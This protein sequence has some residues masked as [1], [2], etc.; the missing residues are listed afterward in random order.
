MEYRCHYMSEA[1]SGI[2]LRILTLITLI[3]DPTYGTSGKYNFWG[4]DI[5]TVSDSYIAMTSSVAIPPGAI[6]HFNHA[7]SFEPPTTMAG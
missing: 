7:Y 2:I 5:C 4:Y 3:G 1:I 6:L